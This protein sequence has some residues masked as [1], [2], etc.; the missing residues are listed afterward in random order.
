[1]G[2]RP[3]LTRR[4]AV[5]RK[6]CQQP[7]KEREKREAEARQDEEGKRREEEDGG[8]DQVK[9]SE[10]DRGGAARYL[11]KDSGRYSLAARNVQSPHF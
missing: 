8:T 5:A 11:C 7:S 1:M 4:L 10:E 9:F 6:G 2:R 3:S